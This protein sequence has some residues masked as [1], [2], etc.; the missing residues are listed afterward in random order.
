MAGMVPSL[1]Q[2][3][4]L[5]DET[6]RGYLVF[7]RHGESQRQSNP[8]GDHDSFDTPLSERGRNQAR[9]LAERLKNRTIHNLYASPLKRAHETATIVEE[10]IGPDVNVVEDLREV[11]I[12]REKALEAMEE[13][14]EMPGEFDRQEAIRSFRW[15][16][17]D[18]TESSESLRQRVT[19]AVDEIVD[20]HPGET[21]VI[22]SH[23]GVINAY[24]TECMGMDSDFITLPAHTSLSTV[25]TLNDN[26]VVVTINDYAH[27]R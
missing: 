15:S 18:Y 23:T 16:S 27:L 24:L 11:D 12:D 17:L 8:E 26:R 20:R 22:F 6:D 10:E 4:F 3:L 7:V 1:L 9:G 21:S 2:K 19:R 14:S 13:S 5:I 25:R